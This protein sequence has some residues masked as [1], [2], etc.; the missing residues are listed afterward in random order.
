LDQIEFRHTLPPEID[1]QIN[2]KYITIIKGKEISKFKADKM[3][4]AITTCPF[5]DNVY[6]IGS[7][8]VVYAWD[9]R[10]NRTSKTYKSMMGQV[11]QYNSDAILCITKM[12]PNIIQNFAWAG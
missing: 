6:L 9:N 8:N 1:W 7:E 4:T 5:D 11:C 3:L 2:K 10:S 12:M